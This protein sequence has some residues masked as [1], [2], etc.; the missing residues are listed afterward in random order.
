M[1]FWNNPVEHSKTLFSFCHKIGK[2]EVS[3]TC[4]NYKILW[5]VNYN[6]QF[7]RWS[8]SK[9]HHPTSLWRRWF[10]LGDSCVFEVMKNWRTQGN[11]VVGREKST[12]DF[13]CG[14]P[15]LLGSFEI[16]SFQH[17]IFSDFSTQFFFVCRWNFC[18]LI[19]WNL[20]KKSQRTMSADG[21]W[22]FTIAFLCRLP[23]FYSWRLMLQALFYL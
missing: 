7:Q 9:M 11:R 14:V 12:L 18:C 6:I 13:H 22:T 15:L 16:V 17:F 5:S 2:I 23:L 20:S 10:E 3:A 21:V 8:C 4:T 19:T 1:L